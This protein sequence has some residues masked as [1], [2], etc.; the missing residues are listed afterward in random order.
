MT[1]G[2]VRRLRVTGWRVG[3]PLTRASG[4]AEVLLVALLSA[5]AAWAGDWEALVADGERW[6]SRSPA[7]WGSCLP[8]MGFCPRSG[9]CNT[10]DNLPPRVTKE[11][12]LSSAPQSPFGAGLFKSHCG[13]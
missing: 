12:A 10:T 13:V 1:G 11:S 5:S 7:T 3:P 8:L 2:L 9:S 4:A 6:W